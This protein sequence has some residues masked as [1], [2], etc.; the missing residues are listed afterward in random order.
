MVELILSLPDALHLRFAISPAGEA[1]RLA[2]AIAAPHR[3]DHAT[4][5]AWLRQHRQGVAR[6]VGEHDVRPLLLLLSARSDDLPE[7]LTPTPSGPI[8][9]IE[10]EFAQIA[11]TPA[12]KAEKEITKCL[13]LVRP[14]DPASERLLRSKDA[15]RM[16]AR[17]LRAIWEALIAPSW[18]Q[19]RN[20]LERDVLYRSRL[21]TEGGLA[22]L[23]A[24]LEPL[25][26]LREQRLVVD[27][28]SD[29]TRE[30][31]GTGL[32]LTPSAFVRSRPLV[33]LGESAP[34]LI[35]PARGIA[36]LFWDRRSRDVTLAKLVG[37][38]R[39]EILEAVADPIHT[40]GLAQ[41]LGH[42]P[43][44]VAEHLHVLLDCGLVAR[45]RLGRK[46]IYSRT[47][48]GDTLLTGATPPSI[49]A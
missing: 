18:P 11:A 13:E 47:A 22:T 39:G 10:A 20:V 28:H 1:V 16:L 15:A 36:A 19:L 38:T 7:F 35:Y 27:V 41:L 23:F 34:T 44:N 32:R 17:Q 31:G 21:L 24:D 29:A 40:T 3:H 33:I 49:R 12:P 6:L 45:A 26:S 37:R 46:V 30:P 42:S 9:E 8:G 2:R 43:A 14:I 4:R 25:L 48:L 5:T